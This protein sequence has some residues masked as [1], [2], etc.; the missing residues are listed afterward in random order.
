MKYVI[1]VKTVFIVYICRR[2]ICRLR[3]WAGLERDRE[4]Y[5]E[6]LGREINR[7]INMGSDGDGQVQGCVG[8]WAGEER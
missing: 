7:G 1:V 4:Q 8:G 3:G 5:T 2:G 6:G